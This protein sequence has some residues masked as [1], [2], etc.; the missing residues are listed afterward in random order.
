[1]QG[2]VKYLILFFAFAMLVISYRG[3]VYF[4]AWST[5]HIFDIDLRIHVGPE[6]LGIG[7]EDS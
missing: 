6:E 5:Y 7:G 4:P 1:M 3:L 2:N